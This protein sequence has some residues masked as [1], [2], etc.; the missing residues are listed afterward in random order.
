MIAA[1]AGQI[2][3][4]KYLLAQ[5]ADITLKDYKVQLTTPL[6][7]HMKLAKQRLTLMVLLV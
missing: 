5:G 1:W 7:F 3:V 6:C 2:D 4:I